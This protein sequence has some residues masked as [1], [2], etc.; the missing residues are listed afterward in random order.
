M[1]RA[2]ASRANP[3]LSFYDAPP[4]PGAFARSP[5]AVRPPPLA[6]ILVPEP[7][8]TGTQ[9]ADEAAER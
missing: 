2:T 6:R 1:A 7:G 4:A 5:V 8:A 9:Q 3:V